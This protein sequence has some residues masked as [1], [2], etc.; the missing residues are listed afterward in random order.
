VIIHPAALRPDVWR[1]IM[2]K[3]HILITGATGQ[4]GGSVLRSL[5]GKGHELYALTRN[6]ESDRARSL[7]SRGIHLLAGDMD[8]PATLE[9]VFSKVRSVFLVGTPFEA[10]THRE[11][12]MG[13]NAVDAAKKAGIDHLVY[14]S[15]ASA[16]KATGIPHFESKHVVEEQLRKSGV[17]FTILAPAFFYDNVMAPF[18]LPGLQQGVLAQA[19][20]KE[21]KLQ[22]VSADDIGKFTAFALENRDTFLGKRIDYAGDELTGPEAAGILGSASGREIQFVELPI[23]Q[24]RESSEDMALMYEWFSRVGYDADIEGLKSGYPEVGW[25]SF[26]RWALRQNWDVLAAAPA[27]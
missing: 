8:N 11:T 4:Q 9:T 12:Q 22:M 1:K 17:P 10:G 7:A 6:V 19:M 26:S 3:L 14:S 27:R 23:A 20:P 2:S 25:E 24:V 5:E 18:A 21:V 16:N 15:V 13:I